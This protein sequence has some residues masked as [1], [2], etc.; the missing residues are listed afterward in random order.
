MSKLKSEALIWFIF[1]EQLKKYQHTC[2]GAPCNIPA[3]VHQWIK[4][5]GLTY[6]THFWAESILNKL[7]SKLD[8]ARETVPLRQLQV[9]SVGWL[10][11]M[12]PGSTVWITCLHLYQVVCA[13]WQCKGEE[14]VTCEILSEHTPLKKHSFTMRV[15]KYW[16]EVSRE[17]VDSLAVEI[18]KATVAQLW[19][20]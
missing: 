7:M 5:P 14:S 9:S 4:P 20:G 17:M 8:F 6:S 12:K 19:A 16:N 1:N 3:M 2:I 18:F 11:S 15:V 10:L 13:Q